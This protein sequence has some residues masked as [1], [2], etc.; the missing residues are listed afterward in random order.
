MVVHSKEHIITG[1]YFGSSCYI[2]KLMFVN[3]GMMDMVSCNALI[4]CVIY[5]NPMVYL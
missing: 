4:S 2:Q 1:L 3:S 5:G